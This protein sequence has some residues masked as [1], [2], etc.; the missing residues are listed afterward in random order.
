MILTVLKRIDING[1]FTHDVDYK[2]GKFE[3]NPEHNSMWVKSEVINISDIK[4]QMQHLEIEVEELTEE[5]RKLL[6]RIHELTKQ[7]NGHKN[8]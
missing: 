7:N 5:N 1:A 4:E 6:V 2:V 3:Y 8:H